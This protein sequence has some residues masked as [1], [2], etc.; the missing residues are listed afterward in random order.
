M[1][2]ADRF[3]GTD[4][5]LDIFSDILNS[6]LPHPITGD[7]TRTKAENAIKQSI[8]NLI[9]TN[10]GE[11]LF[12]P[13]IYSNVMDSLFEFNDTI[14]VDDLRQHV[15]DVITQHEPRC[16]LLNVYVAS[17]VGTGDVTVSIQFSVI[18]TNDIQTLNLLL[19]RVR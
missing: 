12:Q 17:N 2:R 4:K 14:T 19:K 7:L 11:R 5:K 10:R 9:F 16:N 13:D 8:K 15:I 1:S 18:N 6:F 3:T